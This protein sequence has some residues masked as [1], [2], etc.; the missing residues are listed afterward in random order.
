[1]SAWPWTGDQGQAGCLFR[2]GVLLT[3]RTSGPRMLV[4]CSPLVEDGGVGVWGAEGEDGSVAH[5]G[6]VGG[7][8]GGALVVG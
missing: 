7:Q 4:G 1:M 5:S 3:G 6:D 8:L 2:L